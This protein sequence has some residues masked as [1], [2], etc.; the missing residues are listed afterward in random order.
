MKARVKVTGLKALD[1]NLA[2]LHVLDRKTLLRALGVKALEPMRA[3]SARL[4]PNDPTTPQKLGDTIIVSSIRHSGRAIS[5]TREGPTTVNVWMG[6]TKAGYPKAVMAEFGAAPHIITPE[7]VDYSKRIRPGE[8]TSG[9][10]RF[11][12]DGRFIATAAVR[13]PGVA[14][15]PYLR[16][17]FEHNKFEALVIIRWGLRDAV[18]AEVRKMTVSKRD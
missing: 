1:R 4:A 18:A 8:K 7:K 2:R 5:S 10:L 17:S 13:H 3:M 16:P 6:P 11:T 9:L 15:Q 12:D 14:P